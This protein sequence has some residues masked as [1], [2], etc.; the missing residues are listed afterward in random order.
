MSKNS[1]QVQRGRPMEAIIIDPFV[2]PASLPKL[3]SAENRKIWWN[4][5]KKF[6]GANYAVYKTKKAVAGWNP[7]PFAIQAEQD[8]IQMNKAFAEYPMLIQRR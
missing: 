1:A 7:R 5:L 4:R 2:P 8:Y 3:P 6:F